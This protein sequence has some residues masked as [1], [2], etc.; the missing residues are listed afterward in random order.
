MRHAGKA[1][2]KPHIKARM[3]VAHDVLRNKRA[4]AKSKPPKSDQANVNQLVPT[5]LARY[6]PSLAI[7]T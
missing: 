4:Y 2:S 7:S 6:N 5:A 1:D 3:S